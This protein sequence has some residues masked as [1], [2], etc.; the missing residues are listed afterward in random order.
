M[1]PSIW[2]DR[3][4]Y[5]H[6]FRT[7]LQRLCQMH[8]LDF[9]TPHQICNRARQFHA[10][11]AMVGRAERFNCVMHSTMSPC[12][13]GSDLHPFDCAHIVPM[14]FREG[15]P[16]TGKTG[17]SPR[18]AYPNCMGRQVEAPFSSHQLECR[19]NFRCVRQVTLP[20]RTPSQAWPLPGPD[21][22]CRVSTH[23]PPNGIHRVRGS[24][25]HRRC[26]MTS[27]LV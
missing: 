10:S 25:R 7:I 12:A 1:N 14:L 19:M 15:R 9:F 23:P 16:A 2:K 20:R 26:R 22:V 5:H 6:K 24:T 8:G 27:S 3:N 13:S 11:R 21:R 4:L 17:V 18:R